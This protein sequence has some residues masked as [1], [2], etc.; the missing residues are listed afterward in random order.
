MKTKTILVTSEL[1]DKIAEK[2]NISFY[3]GEAEGTVLKIMPDMKKQAMD[4]IGSS[5]TESAAFVLAHL[6][7]ARRREVMEAIF[8]EEGANF[9][10]ARTHIG[11]CDFTL[12]GKYSYLEKEDDTTLE[13]FSI[14]PDYKGFSA[15]DYPGV[16]DEKYDLLPMIKEALEIKRSQEDQ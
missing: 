4:G 6:E 3:K 5:F 9:T 1:G 14:N 10:M 12:E 13:T 15:S 7:P 11:S 2:E 16:N 8:G